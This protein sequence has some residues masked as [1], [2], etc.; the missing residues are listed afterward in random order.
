LFPI[1]YAMNGATTV[2]VVLCWN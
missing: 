1:T 2:P